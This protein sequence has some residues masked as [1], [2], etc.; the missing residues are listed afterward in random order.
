MT[1]YFKRYGVDEHA[2][3]HPGQFDNKLK[4]ALLMFV[5]E[6]IVSRAKFIPS[7]RQNIVLVSR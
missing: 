4:A 5:F 7:Y 6:S 3:T 1:T 2:T